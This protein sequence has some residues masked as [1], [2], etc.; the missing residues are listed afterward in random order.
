MLASRSSGWRVKGDQRS[1]EPAAGEPSWLLERSACLPV[2]R[3]TAAAERGRNQQNR[4]AIKITGQQQW[5]SSF[6]LLYHTHTHTALILLYFLFFFSLYPFFGA[7]CIFWGLMGVRLSQR[8]TG[9]TWKQMCTHTHTHT[10]QDQKL[11]GAFEVVFI[12]EAF[13]LN[14]FILDYLWSISDS[15]FFNRCWDFSLYID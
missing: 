2:G 8:L 7:P 6:I 15:Y 12:R 5:L 11:T 10:V 3:H 9:R 1:W 13:Q 4:Q 14:I